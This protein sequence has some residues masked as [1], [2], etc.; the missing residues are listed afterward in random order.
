MTVGEL[1]K[2]LDKYD[3]NTEIVIRPRYSIFV[4]KIHDIGKDKLLGFRCEN[5]NVVVIAT[6]EQLGVTETRKEV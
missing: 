2:E 1:V 4:D 5:K 3:E 6:S